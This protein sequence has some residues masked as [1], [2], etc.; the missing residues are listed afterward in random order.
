MHLVRAI[1]VASGPIPRPSANGPANWDVA[2]LCLELLFTVLLRNR[3]RIAALWPRTYEHFHAI[4][5]C[6]RDV[7]A[8]LVQK[9]GGEF[10]GGE[11]EEGGK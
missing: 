6:S 3:D 10:A 5:S 8:V 7:D 4:F 9:V 2:E 1:I 11:G